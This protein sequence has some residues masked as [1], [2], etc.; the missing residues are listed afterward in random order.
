MGHHLKALTVHNGSNDGQDDSEKTPVG[1][2]GQSGDGRNSR[3]TV[4]LEGSQRAKQ[5]TDG[6]IMHSYLQ[7]SGSRCPL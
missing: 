1:E 6:E 5:T 4:R 7:E 3:G 2:M